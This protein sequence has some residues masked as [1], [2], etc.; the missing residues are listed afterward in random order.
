MYYV[1]VGV[2][3]TVVG[4]AVDADG[5]VAWWTVPLVGLVAAWVAS[6][7]TALDDVRHPWR[8]TRTLLAEIRDPSGVGRVRARAYDLPLYTLAPG[9]GGIRRFSAGGWTRGS[10]LFSPIQPSAGVVWTDD[11]ARLETHTVTRPERLERARRMPLGISRQ[12][13]RFHD[14]P[15]LQGGATDD[16]VAALR[17]GTFHLQGRPLYATVLDLAESGL[18]WVAQARIDDRYV[19]ELAGDGISHTSLTLIMLSVD[20]LPE[21]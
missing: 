20:D 10:N 2:P 15:S 9:R 18:G 13:A 1:V 8:S 7:L 16:L 4:V 21:P 17:P 12:L 5:L 11:D 6:W 14:D 3:C 19:L